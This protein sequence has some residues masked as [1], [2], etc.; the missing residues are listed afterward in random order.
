MLLTET[1]KI[2]WNKNQKQNYISKGYNYTKMGDEFEIKVKDLPLE[3]QA[4]VE[5]KCD[6]C[7]SIYTIP[8]EDI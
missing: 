7:G 8:L 4:I 1:V 2:R 3:N 6:Y 5:V